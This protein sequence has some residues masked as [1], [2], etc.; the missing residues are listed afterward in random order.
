M[1]DD[2]KLIRM[3]DQMIPVL[4]SLYSACNQFCEANLVIQGKLLEL[5]KQALEAKDDV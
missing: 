3:V 1:T 2:E 4:E 5:K